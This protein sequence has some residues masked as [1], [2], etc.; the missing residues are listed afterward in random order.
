M[1]PETLDPRFL[2]PAEA[3]AA[4]FKK[5]GPKPRGTAPG[6]PPPR[7]GA[8]SFEG[9]KKWLENF[10]RPLLGVTKVFCRPRR[11]SKSARGAILGVP[12]RACARSWL[13]ACFW[14]GFWL[15][16]WCPGGPR[17]P[18]NQG[19]R[20]DCLQK[21]RCSHFPPPTAKRRA[22]LISRSFQ[23]GAPSAFRDP[24]GG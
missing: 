20:V 17:N 13:A 1:A 24:L 19:F 18:E 6:D 12:E 7:G 15:Q 22:K 8:V 23:N 14:N 16:K 9:G 11:V 3:P 4:I 21:L 5:N 2:H 10:P